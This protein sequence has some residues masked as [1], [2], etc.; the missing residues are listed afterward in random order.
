LKR[1]KAHPDITN[2]NRQKNRILNSLRKPSQLKKLFYVVEDHDFD[3][4][5]TF[6]EQSHAIL[7]KKPR[8]Q[9]GEPR[10]KGFSKDKLL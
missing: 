9:E 6:R 2:E 7:Q 8:S 4:L 3:I 1:P 5:A 10:G